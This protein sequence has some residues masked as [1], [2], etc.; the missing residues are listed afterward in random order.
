M[1]YN[2]YTLHCSSIW[3]SRV[4]CHLS[5][6][7]GCLLNMPACG[8]NPNIHTAFLQKF[9]WLN[10]WHTSYLLLFK[11]NTVDSRKL[12][13]ESWFVYRRTTN[14]GG[15]SIRSTTTL[16]QLP[17]KARTTHERTQFFRHDVLAWLPPFA[18]LSLS[19]QPTSASTKAIPYT[20][21]HIFFQR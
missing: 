16:L 7:R 14:M 10:F 6:G 8:S 21:F 15:N 3:R 1:L 18:S 20:S 11:I 19:A 9:F 12:H 4:T 17:A 2:F 5:R 13:A